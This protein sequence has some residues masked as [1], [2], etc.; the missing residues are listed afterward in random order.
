MNQYLDYLK[1]PFVAGLVSGVVIITLAYLDQKMND[2]DF[3][4]NYFVKLFAGVF[5]LVTG[6][7]YFATSGS[8]SRKQV[9][10]GH[11]DVIIKKMAGNGLDI[12]TDAPDF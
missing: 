8:S 12:Y 3:D 5:I 1:N 9:G 6:L 11:S 4:S 10:G 2:R 7:V